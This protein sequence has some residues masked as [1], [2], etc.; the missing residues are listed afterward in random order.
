MPAP[1][2]THLPK[3]R[4]YKPKD[5]AVVRIDGRDHYGSEESKEKYRRLLAEWLAGRPPEAPEPA[6]DTE[7]ISIAEL[8]LAYLRWA[9]GYYRKDGRPTRETINIRLALRPLRQL[10]GLTPARD[11]GPLALK[12]VRQAMIDACLCR[13]ECNKRTR[14]VVRLFKWAVE[15]EHVPPAVHQGLKAVAGL[16]K[17]RSAAR[18][19]EPVRPVDDVWVDAVRPFVSRQVWAMI[20]LQRLTG[21]RPGEVVLMRTGDID[22]S[23]RVWEYVPHA[24]KTEHHGRE[25][26]I[27]LGP[28][29]QEVLRPWLRADPMA[30]LFS[31][32]EATEERNAARRCPPR[33]RPGHGNAG[34]ARHRAGATRPPPTPTRSPRLAAE[35]SRTRRSRR[36]GVRT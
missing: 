5:L 16:R 30:Y 29:A 27:F 10:Y 13:N 25:R 23:G 6:A 12:A 20:E 2:P 31:P 11:F 33:N 18:E 28:K 3:Y 19:S 4:H 9:D 7:G 17:G 35:L 22:R 36:S 26:R 8:M 21:M 32:S 14:I 34:P 15:H 1:P 24:H